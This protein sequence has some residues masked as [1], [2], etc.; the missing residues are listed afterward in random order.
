[1]DDQ[2]KLLKK[3][4]RRSRFTQFLAWLALFFTAVGIA[5]GYKNWLRIHDKAKLALRQIEEIRSEIP[6]FA[7]QEKLAILEKELNDNFKENKAHLDEAMH[8]LRTIQDSTQHIADSVYAQAQT[9]THQQAPVKIQTPTLKDWSLGE[10]HFLLQTAVQ[11]FELKKDKDSAIVS[12]KLADTLLLERGEL[13]LLPVRKQI[14]EDIAIVNQYAAVDI[15]EVSEKIDDLLKQLEP[16]TKQA[17]ESSENIQ[18]IP[19]SDNSKD[20]KAADSK[21]KETL[22]SRVKKTIND[23]VI[24]RKLDKPLQEDLDLDSKDRLYQLFSLRFET[25]KIMLLQ[26]DD[27]NYHKQIERIK[28]L[29]VNYYSAEKNTA[30]LEQLKILDQI[31][32]S[33]ELPDAN[34]SLQ[35]LEKI[36]IE[37]NIMDK[38]KNQNIE[39]ELK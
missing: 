34:D 14:S 24:I 23:A 2:L 3:I 1:M 25:L 19:S 12:F 26:G 13:D 20:V 30:Y 22:V 27:V 39:A 17:P 37:K 29:L 6:N 38:D 5:A 15:S 16:V 28:S 35:L 8:E 10:V 33:P 32:L 7:L 9:L 11:Q 18:L 21:A 36:M 31:S 4:N